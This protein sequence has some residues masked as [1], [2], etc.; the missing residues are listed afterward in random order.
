MHNLIY[1]NHKHA[2][3]MWH[4][5]FTG[6]WHIKLCVRVCD[7][8]KKSEIIWKLGYVPIIPHLPLLTTWLVFL[9]CQ[10]EAVCNQKWL[11]L[12]IESVLNRNMA[13]WNEL[14]RQK[15]KKFWCD[16]GVEKNALLIW[17]KLLIEKNTNIKTTSTKLSQTSRSK[18]K[19]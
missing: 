6:E 2:V 18:R 1:I 16:H 10:V 5:Y 3:F 11:I 4:T 14:K 15:S 19:N 7:D 9:S 17:M 8:G 12:A 13:I